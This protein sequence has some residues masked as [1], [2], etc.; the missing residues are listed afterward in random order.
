M[1]EEGE[2]QVWGKLM[3]AGELE[4]D[5]ILRPEKTCNYVN[6]IS[7]FDSIIPAHGAS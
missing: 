7:T 1:E 6:G 5:E 4:G 2:R 3:Q